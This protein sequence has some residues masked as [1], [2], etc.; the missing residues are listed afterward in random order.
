MVELPTWVL[1]MLVVVALLG[2]MA[3][4]VLGGLLL[5]EKQNTRVLRNVANYGRT[6]RPQAKTRTP[7]PPEKKAKV[8]AEKKALNRAI[9]NAAEDV[10][11]RARKQG[12]NITDEQ[13]RQEA[14]RIIKEGH[15]KMG[16]ST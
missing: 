9:E 15:S 3:A 16:G 11:R 4:A 5:G 1:I 13:A 6:E 2:W 8:R 14:R 7:D 10:K 12:N